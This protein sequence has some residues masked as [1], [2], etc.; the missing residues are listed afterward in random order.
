[1]WDLSVKG[2][3]K[4]Y[5]NGGQA[6]IDITLDVKE[7]QFLA[8]LGK[9]GAGKTTFVEILSSLTQKTSGEVLIRG[10]DL[11]KDNNSVKSLV[12][13]VPQEFNL[14]IF[15]NT[16][17]TLITQAGYFGIEKATA[18]KRAENLLKALDLW[19]KK[20]Q[21]VITLSGG[22]KRR[23]M[24]ARALMHD[25]KIIFFDEPTAGV[26]VEVRQ[27]IWT[28][29]QNL[30]KEGKTIVLTTHYFEEAEKLCDSLAIIHK[31]KII[32]HD[33]LNNI[34]H[35]CPK[36][37]Y[38]IELEN[39]QHLWV[40]APNIKVLS[41]NELEVTISKEHGL[42]QTI[43]QIISQGAVIQNIQLKNSRLEELFLNMVS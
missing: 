18:Y 31:G 3:S 6:L 34:F 11:E 15:E 21:A 33:S 25:P 36:R 29:L 14:A 42:N 41:A 43:E 28:I 13:I 40:E 24:I 22:M 26:D 7:G 17:Q 38:L 39:S 19:E 5:E 30:N 2:L 4:V 1:M 10:K 16:M 9:N 37:K 35:K 20:D 27:K 8:L 23:L 12:G 32:I